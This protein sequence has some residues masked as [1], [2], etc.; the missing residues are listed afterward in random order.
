MIEKFREEK[1]F[2]GRI[3]RAALWQFFDLKLVKQA[4]I[5]YQGSMDCSLCAVER[6]VIWL[7]MR[8]GKAMNRNSD[9]YGRCRHLYKSCVTKFVV[10]E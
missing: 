6:G 8:K 2:R 1:N 4:K 10:E 3:G 7:M 9:L 5:K